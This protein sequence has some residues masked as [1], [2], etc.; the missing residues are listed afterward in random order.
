M[1]D[2]SCG[3]GTGT[4]LRHGSGTS[5]L[6]PEGSEGVDCGLA[7]P[8]PPPWTEHSDRR[9]HRQKIAAGAPLGSAPPRSIARALGFRTGDNGHSMIDSAGELTGGSPERGCNLAR[10]SGAS[11]GQSGFRHGLRKG[12]GGNDNRC[13][14]NTDCEQNWSTHA[15]LPR[16][17]DS[18]PSTQNSIGIEKQPAPSRGNREQS[19]TELCS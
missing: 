2:F 3:F 8:A 10:E 4:E 9:C 5:D 13:K 18:I 6:R 14:K 19:R 16:G 15:Q 7:H 1:L 11:M 17:A 12:T